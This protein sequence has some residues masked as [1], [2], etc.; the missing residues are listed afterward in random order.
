MYSQLKFEL[1]KLEP[2]EILVQNNVDDDINDEKEEEEP[3]EKDNQEFEKMNEI[4]NIDSNSHFFDS[5]DKS[6]E[7]SECGE[8]NKEFASQRL[9]KEHIR[10]DHSDKSPCWV[11]FKI[12]ASTKSLKMHKKKHHGKIKVGQESFLQC[13]F[14]LISPFYQ[15][16][17]ILKM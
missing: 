10:L 17:Y 9:L 8:C 14:K 4:D 15:I 6:V 13:L 7:N 5:K 11:C 16:F 2:S 3:E 1:I 12:F